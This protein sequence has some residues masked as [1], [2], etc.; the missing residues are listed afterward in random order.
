MGVLLQK[1]IEIVLVL[2]VGRGQMWA[3]SLLPLLETVA[4]L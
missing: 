2:L 1:G 3:G 4:L